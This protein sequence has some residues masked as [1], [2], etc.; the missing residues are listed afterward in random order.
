MQVK[1]YAAGVT[2][3]T[4]FAAF[5]TDV[6]D[7]KTVLKTDLGIDPADSLETRVQVAGLVCAFKT[8]QVRS[9]RYAEYEGELDAKHMTKPLP[10]SDMMAMRKA[11]EA[12]YWK[13]EDIEVP[14][15]SYLE[16]RLMEEIERGDVRAEPLANVFNKDEE[17]PDVLTPVWTGAGNLTLKRGQYKGEPPAGPEVLRKRLTLMGVG[18]AMMGFRHTNRPEPQGIDPQLID[19]NQYLSYLLGDYCYNLMA[20]SSDGSAIA[21]PAWSQVIAYEL[22][23]RK[24][25]WSLA[26]IRRRH[27]LGR[28]PTGLGG[29]GRQG[30][31]LHYAS[32]APH[33]REARSGQQ[34]RGWQGQE[35]ASKRR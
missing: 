15:R 7:F 27:L 11:Y 28:P 5:A 23:I 31:P 1:L 22:A 10:P 35:V 26:K 25:A 32:G 33:G 24:R 18:L 20:R 21:A 2:R 19:M 4:R 17:Q 16:Q 9:A 12:R 3:L 34:R 29:P 30:A 14:S 13:L 8:A 6:A